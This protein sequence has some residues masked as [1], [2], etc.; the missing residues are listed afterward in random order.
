MTNVIFGQRL[1]VTSERW[2]LTSNMNVYKLVQTFSDCQY[3][4]L[5]LVKPIT[6]SNPEL[7]QRGSSPSSWTTGLRHES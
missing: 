7:R 5:K 2:R 4:D 1:N 6:S 3:Y